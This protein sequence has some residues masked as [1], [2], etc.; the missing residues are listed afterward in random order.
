MPLIIG[1]NNTFTT[2]EWKW[3]NTYTNSYKQDAY[4]T[5]SF[6]DQWGIQQLS[7]TSNL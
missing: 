2:N 4:T 7:K 3:Y 5:N 1:F 6:S